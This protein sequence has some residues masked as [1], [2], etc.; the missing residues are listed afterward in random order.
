[1]DD[2]PSAWSVSPAREIQMKL[3]ALGFV[4]TQPSRVAV[5]GVT[6]KVEDLSLRVTLLLSPP[7]PQ[8]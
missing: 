3:W 4:L 6:Q 8:A 1:M 7:P 2:G 5:W